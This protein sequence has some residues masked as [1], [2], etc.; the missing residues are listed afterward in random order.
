MTLHEFITMDWNFSW[1]REAKLHSP[2][3]YAENGQFD[4]R[5]DQNPFTCFPT[6]Y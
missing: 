6:E 3:L 4:V 5:P 1:P 2:L